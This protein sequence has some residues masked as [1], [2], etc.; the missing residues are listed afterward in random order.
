MTIIQ[1]LAK[2][3]LNRGVSPTGLQE[4][5]NRNRWREDY[6]NEDFAVIYADL[7]NFKAYNDVY[8][9]ANGDEVINLQGKYYQIMCIKWNWRR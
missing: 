2:S 4:C 1:N 7:D 9:F 6:N 8:G 3:I 5:S